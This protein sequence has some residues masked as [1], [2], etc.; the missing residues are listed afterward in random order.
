MQKISYNK[1][2]KLLM[3]KQKIKIVRKNDEYSAEYQVGDVFQVDSTWYGGVNVTSASGIPLSLDKD[4]YVLLEEAEKEQPIDNYSYQCGVMDCFCEM[5]ASGLKKLAMSHPCDT[6]A[7]RDSYLPQVKK[8]CEKYGILYHPQDEAL[9]TD[10]FPAEANQDK[11]NYL[12]FRTQ[13]VYETYLELKKR[14]KELENQCGGTEEERYQ[15]AADFGALLRERRIHKGLTEE[16]VAAELKITS[17]LVKAIEEG[18]MESMPHAVYARGFIRAYAKLLAV[19]DSVT[20][21]AC[22]LLKDPEEELREQ[23][24]RVVPAAARREESH[25]PWLAILLCA[26]FLAGGAWYF[27]DSIP[28]LSSNTVSREKTA[29]PAVSSPAVP[30]AD[31]VVTTPAIPVELTANATLPAASEEPIVL[32]GTPLPAETETPT[33]QAALPA[34]GHRMLLTAQGD[35]WVSTTADGKNSQRVMHKGDTLNVDFQEKLVMKLGNAGAMLI[36][37]DGKELPP[38]GKIGQVKTVTFPND[39]QN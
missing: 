16:N 31:T 25:V 34:T 39:A 13:D 1:E 33:E 36:T 32:G 5:V 11:Y 28:G 23:E 19:D 29:S 14:Q 2:I 21:A 15:L 30:E 3:E 27:R 20:H 26:L 9:I 6:K 7:E 8:L 38:V 17:R 12:F 4:E 22:A 24:I 37:Y 10:L 35:C 18:D